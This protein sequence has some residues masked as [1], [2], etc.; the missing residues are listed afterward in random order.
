MRAAVMKNWSLRVDD[1][2]VPTPGN[3]QVLAKV[4]A[5]GI[6]G[7]DLHLLVHGEESRRLGEELASETPPD[8]M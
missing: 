7:S 2:A 1:I 5:C 3:G 4:L 8:A 6:C